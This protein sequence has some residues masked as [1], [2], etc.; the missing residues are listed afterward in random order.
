MSWATA[1]SDH[2]HPGLK[3]QNS[4]TQ[5]SA[6]L[7]PCGVRGRLV[8]A[9]LPLRVLRACLTSRPCGCVTPISGSVFTWLRSLCLISSSKDPVIGLGPTYSWLSSS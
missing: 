4:E 1:P 2:K 6:G 7:L 8:Q 9:S 3:Q 5:V